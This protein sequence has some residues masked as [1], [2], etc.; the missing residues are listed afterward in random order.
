MRPSRQRV[1]PW[2]PLSWAKPRNYPWRVSRRGVIPVDLSALDL[3]ALDLS[4]LDL[5]ALDL[6]ALDLSAL[7]L[8][9]NRA[10]P[11]G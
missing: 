7:V 5:S 9:L 10:Q 6:S 8:V 2:Y 4:A 1:R 3:S 11:G